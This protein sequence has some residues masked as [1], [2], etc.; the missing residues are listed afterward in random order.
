M[1]PARPAWQTSAIEE[2]RLQLLSGRR[3]A[4]NV[5]LAVSALLAAAVFVFTRALAISPQ[6]AGCA[7]PSEAA[8]ALYVSLLRPLLW[9]QLGVWACSLVLCALVA[10]AFF[11]AMGVVE[12]TTEWISQTSA[13]DDERST[14]R[15]MYYERI[16][17]KPRQRRFMW[18]GVVYACLVVAVFW[19]VHIEDATPRQAVST[20]TW[21]ALAAIPYIVSVGWHQLIR[22][23]NRANSPY[24]DWYL[25]SRQSL[26][27]NFKA[28]V[29]MMIWLAMVGWL[30]VVPVFYAMDWA[31]AAGAGYL[32]QHQRYD[33]R[34]ESLTTHGYDPAQS[35]SPRL[36]ALPEPDDLRA[37]LFALGPDAPLDAWR[38]VFPEVLRRLFLMLTVTAVCAVG[39]PALI[40]AALSRTSRRATW[41]LLA[42]TLKSSA[43]VLF[44]RLF[45]ETAYRVDTSGLAGS[46]A[47]FFL[48]VSYFLMQDSPSVDA[49]PSRGLEAR[50]AGVQPN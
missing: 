14:R 8:A 16:L 42:A 13:P 17:L 27:R 38:P 49:L 7:L 23:R 41:V 4:L 33:A 46:A 20:L 45:I 24:L 21:C 44:M 48:A 10:Y 28:V 19:F 40:W 3:F 25:F 11:A 34:W 32:R 43:L 9:A 22:F 30:F 29:N 5:L 12:L 6:R 1:A 26:R 36:A 2:F 50:R 35:Y 15:R 31:S 39:A 18:A 47:V 37:W